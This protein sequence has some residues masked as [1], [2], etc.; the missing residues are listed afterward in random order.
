MGGKKKK[1]D[2]INGVICLTFFFLN[3]SI[4]GFKMDLLR[5]DQGGTILFSHI[6]KLSWVC[7][8]PKV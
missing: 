6:K 5:I 3:F 4:F 7:K 2:I 1:W 8:M